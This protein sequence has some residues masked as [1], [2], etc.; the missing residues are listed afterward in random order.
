MAK[1]S[2]AREDMLNAAVDIDRSQSAPPVITV[3]D[4]AAV[5]HGNPQRPGQLIVFIACGRI[6]AI[7]TFRNTPAGIV[8]DARCAIG[9]EAALSIKCIVD[10]TPDRAPIA[11]PSRE[12]PPWSGAV[13]TR[14][15]SGTLVD[16]DLHPVAGLLHLRLDAP[17]GTVWTG[18][19]RELGA[20]GRFA[21]TTVKPGIVAFDADRDQV[22]E[23]AR[24]CGIG[25]FMLAG[26][27]P[28]TWSRQREIAK[29]KRGFWWSA[30]LHPIAVVRSSPER[31]S[32]ALRA[33]PECFRGSHAASALGE[34]GL[35]ARFVPRDS[36]DVQQEAFREQVAIARAH[37]VPLI[38]HVLGRGVEQLLGLTPA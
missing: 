33:L 20:D 14:H 25:G 30:G 23:R 7:A 9:D 28:D 16:A 3:A 32:S 17:D 27:D 18:I 6:A 10:A 29:S 24:A 13:A 38:L 11:D 19:D 22:V 37:D 5:E 2:S 36:L 1:V 4:V 31:R 12:L 8:P 26:V 35:D 21:F 15:I 34:T